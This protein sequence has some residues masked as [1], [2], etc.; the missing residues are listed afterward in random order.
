MHPRVT[1]RNSAGARS[2]SKPIVEARYLH[3]SQLPVS[4]LSA[5]DEAVPRIP[6]RPAHNSAAATAFTTR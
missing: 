3:Q 6:T 1:P 2:L 5:P 4:K